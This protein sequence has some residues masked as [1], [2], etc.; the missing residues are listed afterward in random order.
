[1]NPRRI[2][3]NPTDSEL[4]QLS[5]KHHAILFAWRSGVQSYKDLCTQ[6]SIPIGTVRSRLNRARN[7]LSKLRESNNAS[8]SQNSEPS[9]GGG[10]DNL[11]RDTSR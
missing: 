5:T 7:A 2:I 9:V 8:L 6:L 1:M 4:D 11:A 3:T 10:A